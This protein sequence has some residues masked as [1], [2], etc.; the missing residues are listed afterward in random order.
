MKICILD[1]Y[2]ANP[3]DLSWEALAALAPLSVYDR[4]SPSQVLE[5]AWDAEIVLTNKTV[6]DADK[7]AQLPK[8]Q[9]I[10][11]L[12]TGYN[13][14]DL[15]AAKA[16]GIVVTNIPSYST[17]SVAQTV[18]AHLL[19]ITHQ[20]ARH[21]ALVH[22]GAWVNSP[23]FMFACSPLMEISGKSMGIV[24]LGN[25]GKAVAAIALAF[26]MKVLAYTSKTQE[27]LQAMFPAVPQE[28]L[29][30][31]GKEEVFAQSDVLSLHCPLN[32]ETFAFVNAGMLSLM[33]STA[34]VIN[35]GRGPLVDEQAL[36][37]ALNEGR[38]YAA[39]VDVLSTEPP[40]ADNP[41]LSAAHCFISPHFAW[42]TK[43][44]RERL[45]RIATDNVRAFLQGCP[46]HRVC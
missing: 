18:F 30:K 37:D 45:I 25:T 7:I 9:Y 2:T 29:R 17:A 5:R 12:A 24:G 11:V 4:T 32:E 38:I 39:A 14:V 20:V 23:D 42:A 3:G 34:I 33:K 41:L 19:N 46:Q 43:E 36:A 6:L 31:V 13:V 40:K 28:N 26:G 44:A 22:E 21:D 27:E 16:R 15:A 35:T 1:A 10:G 8:L